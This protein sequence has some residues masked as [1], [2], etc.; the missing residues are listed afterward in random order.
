[1]DFVTQLLLPKKDNHGRK[2]PKLQYAPFHARMMQRFR[3]WTRK[4]QVEGAW[5]GLS[6]K[7]IIDSLGIR[8]RTF[9]QS[10]GVLGGRER[11]AESGVRARRDLDDTIRRP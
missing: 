9:A 7:I 10:A 1:M 2:Y 6:G 4:G 5:L 11:A 8:S 3:G